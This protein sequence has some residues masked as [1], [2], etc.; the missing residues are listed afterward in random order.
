MQNFVR[1]NV[2]KYVLSFLS[3]MCVL[4][5]SST[6][7]AQIEGCDP[8]VLELQQTKSQAKVAYDIAATE[9][10]LVKPDSVLA[11][12]CFNRSAGVSAERGGNLFS[13][14]F[15]GNGS[16]I[17][18]ITDML[19]AFFAQFIDAEAF[20]NPGTAVLYSTAATNLQDN[21]ECTGVENMWTRIKEKGVSGGVPMATFQ[22]LLD[23]I[24]PS[25]AGS[26]FI[27][28]FNTAAGDEIFSD[29]SYAM[30]EVNELRP[31]IPA[32]GNFNRICDVLN[33]PDL[34]MGYTVP[35]P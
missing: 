19:Q 26:R 17:S 8:R 21:E 15:I 25:G 32:L 6:A 7:Q 10:I 4:F 22:D 24:I 5:F 31:D 33:D 30:D 9:Q 2:S 14:S 16:F 35:C 23:G 11:L 29:L 1:F 3:V 13:G 12:T 18:L 27:A 20:E 34:A 28:N